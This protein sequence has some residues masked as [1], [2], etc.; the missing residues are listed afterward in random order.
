[1][2][3]EEYLEEECMKHEFL[4]PY[5]PQQNGKEEQDTDQHGEGDA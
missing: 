4:A 5:T 3:V 2:Q 1:L